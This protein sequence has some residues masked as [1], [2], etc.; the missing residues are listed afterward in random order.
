M[1]TLQGFLLI[2]LSLDIEAK[3]HSSTG[4]EKNCEVV[5]TAEEDID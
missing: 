3:I 1:L 2:A 4:I 5:V